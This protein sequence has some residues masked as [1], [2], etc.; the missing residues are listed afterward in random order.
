MPHSPS[1][2][3]KSPT[4]T[5]LDS[6]CG[7]LPPKDDW[8]SDEAMGRRQPPLH[9]SQ[10]DGQGEGDGGA[11]GDADGGDDSGEGVGPQSSQ[12]VPA[13]HRSNSDPGPPSSQAPSVEWGQV[14]EHPAGGAQCAYGV[15]SAS[16]CSGMLLQL[17]SGAVMQ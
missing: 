17:S 3:Q 11:L 10:P 4:V 1:P 6:Q 16:Q 7:V 12:S 2:S 13:A 8:H 15:H 5:E 14:F 9:G